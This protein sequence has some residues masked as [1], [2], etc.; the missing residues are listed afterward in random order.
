[1]IR[2]FVDLI[3]ILRGRPDGGKDEKERAVGAEKSVAESKGRCDARAS[4][5]VVEDRGYFVLAA[6]HLAGSLTRLTTLALRGLLVVAVSLDFACQSFTLTKTLEALQHLLDRFIPTR[7]HLNHELTKPSFQRLTSTLSNAQKM[8]GT[9]SINKD[10]VTDQSP[11]GEI[12]SEEWHG[13][14]ISTL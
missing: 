5:S 4:G 10:I 8:N 6:V 1:M 14:L 12:A 9:S 3:V 7:F 2:R 13:S 11:F